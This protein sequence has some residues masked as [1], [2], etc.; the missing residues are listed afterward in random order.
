[1]K[2]FLLIVFFLLISGSLLLAQIKRPVILNDPDYDVSKPLKFGFSLGLNMMDLDIR[3]SN[4]LETDEDGKTFQYFSEVTHINPGLNVNA[5][6]DL[7][8]TENFHLRFL[9]G[10]SFGQRNVDF[11]RV[12]SDKSTL[13]TTM[14]IESSFIEMPLGVKYQSQRF[15]NV[16][17]YLLF[18]GNYRIDLAA[19]KRLK[20]EKG[21]LIRLE[22]SD[23]YY[24]IGFGVDFFLTYFKFSA[25]IKWS[26]GIFNAISNDFAEGAENYRNA[27]DHMR[28]QLIIISFHFE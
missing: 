9:P 25:E 28:S 12:D 11:F 20:V 17:P 5:I 4:K 27:I 15:N 22:K 2:R 19:Y 21:V 23:F 10:Y 13:E 7:R 16:R 3:N 6:C 18:G 26:S 8:L 14:N 24:E 1:M